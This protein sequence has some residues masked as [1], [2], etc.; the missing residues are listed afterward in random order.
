MK[1]VVIISDLYYPDMSAP[2]AVIDKYVQVLKRDDI[3]FHIVTVSY[4]YNIP[5]VRDRNIHFYYVSSIKTRIRAYASHLQA[6]G[7]RFIGGLLM[8]LVKFHSLLMHQIAYPFTTAWLIDAYYNETSKIIENNKIDCIIS[9]SN[10]ICSQF[11][12][13]KIKETYPFV[14]WITFFTDPFTDHYIYYPQLKNKP[15]LRKRHYSD[16]L[17]IYNTADYNLLTAE[18]YKRAINE[19][20]QD[21]NKTYK[22]LYSLS[23][24]NVESDGHATASPLITMIFAGA[25]YKNIRNPEGMLKVVSQTNNLK[26][27]LYIKRNACSDIVEHYLCDRIERKSVVG[28][29]AYLK[30]INEDYDILINIGNDSTLQTPSKMLELLSTGKPIANFFKSK[31]EQYY[32]IEKYPLGINIYSEDPLAPQLLED[33][34]VKNRNKRMAYAD[35]EALFP[36]NTIERQAS[37]LLKLI[38]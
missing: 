3:C 15:A 29:E 13:L 8:K 19:F 25:L 22:I 1:N 30:M 21:I 20:H 10:T 9:V 27:D 37:L 4:A 34:C 33:F 18:L 28:R 16:E 36:E 7:H 24:Q 26:L 23:K 12:A 17:K 38:N 32:L 35:V 11:A 6:N 14:K 31:D 5:Q 2:S